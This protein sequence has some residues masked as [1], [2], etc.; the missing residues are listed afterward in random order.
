MA[1]CKALSK[2]GRV[3]QGDIAE[4]AH[5]IELLRKHKS[6]NVAGVFFTRTAYQDGA[7]KHASWEGISIAVCKPSD[8]P[9]HIFLTYHKYDP[10]RDEQ[11]RHHL[12]YSSIALTEDMLMLSL[13]EASARSG[14]SYDQLSDAIS[15]RKLR[16]RS[17]EGKML[18]MVADLNEFVAVA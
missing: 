11:I 4:F 15:S 2:P 9:N 14:L 1:E 18:I 13:A 7:I 5:K 10:V 12:D 17:L 16:A 6:S 8:R 3:K